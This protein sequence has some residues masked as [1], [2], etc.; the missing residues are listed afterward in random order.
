MSTA[1]WARREDARVGI[2]PGAPPVPKGM[3]TLDRE[4]D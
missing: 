3:T 1:Q 2:V 4:V